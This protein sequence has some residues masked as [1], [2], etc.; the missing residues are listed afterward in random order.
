MILTYYILVTIH[1]GLLDVLN[2]LVPDKIEFEI[3][4][5]EVV[6]FFLSKLNE[7]LMDLQE[8]FRIKRNYLLLQSE[9]LIFLLLQNLTVTKYGITKN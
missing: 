9:I 7:L 2:L 4:D 8:N 6:S 3:R 1:L 5:S